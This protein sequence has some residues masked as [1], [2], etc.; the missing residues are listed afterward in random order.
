MNFKKNI[1]GNKSKIAQCSFC[2]KAKNVKFIFAD[3]KFNFF[4]CFTC[5][6]GFTYPYPKPKELEKYYHENYWVTPGLL[7]F[8]R[9]YVFDFFQT[10][11]KR[12]VMH[13][14]S[15]GKILDVGAGEAKFAKSLGNRYQVTSL[16]IP[17]SKIINKNILKVNFLKWQ[18][19]NRFNAIVFWES[20]EHT[21]KPEQYLQKAYKLLKKDGFMFI[22][23]PRFDSFESRFFNKY[24]FHLDPPRH[25]SYITEKGLELLVSRTGLLRVFHGSVAA[26]EYAIWGF[27]GSTLNIINLRI[28]DILKQNRSLILL[29]LLI[30]FFIMVVFIEI[31]FAI[32]GQSPIGLMIAKKESKN[33]AP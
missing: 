2:H 8:F 19:S 13:Y 10:R 14:L 21:S 31:F 17:S 28:T 24:W 26:F 29:F 7:G 33:L 4:F 15:K 16:D 32:I 3:R 11:R 1:T 23:Y 5:H 9:K 30:P 6:M 25:Y 27:I 20:L 18:T 12:W 22:E